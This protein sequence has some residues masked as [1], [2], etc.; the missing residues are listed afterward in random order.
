VIPDIL[1][2]IVED[3]RRRI[4][5]VGHAQGL[6]ELIDG[7]GGANSA[8]AGAGA[9]IAAGAGT[10]APAVPFPG[11][12]I[13]E[14]K[15]RSPSR[16][17]LAADADPV[18]RAGLYRAAGATSVSVLT[19]ED[20]FA[21]S[22]ADLIAVKRAYP[23]LAV[24]R[25]DFLLD[26]E[27]LRVSR[28]A[29]ADAVLL[30][31]AIL[32]RPT[33]ARLLAEAERLGLAALVEVHNEAELELVAPLRPKLLGINSRDLRTF[34]VDLLGPVA[35]SERIDW[36]CRTVFESGVFGRA[37]ARLARDAGFGSVLVG[38]AVVKD[39]RRVSVLVE[40]MN[41]NPGDARRGRGPAGPSAGS[42]WTEI[43]RRRRE[44][45]LEA[46]L[47][48]LVKVCGITNIEDARLAVDLGADLLG[49]IYATS[50]RTAPEGLAKELRAA[51]ITV[52]LVGVV[53]E[54]EMLP[55]IAGAA[56]PEAIVFLSRA[57]ADLR[58]GYLSAL[59]LHGASPPE[60]ALEF[61][62]PAY[63]AVRF[64]TP[65][66]ATTTIPRIVTPRFLVDAYDSR[67]AGG[68]GHSVSREIMDTVTTAIDE[69]PH[70]AL[71][72]AGGL[73]PD[74][75]TDA[76]RRW[77]PELID[78]SGGLEAEPGR[79]DPDRLR[80]FFAAVDAAS[81]DDSKYDPAAAYAATRNDRRERKER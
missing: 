45:R 56:V 38:E 52:P 15:R 10:H 43:A 50:P 55:G 60:N 5:A 68:T 53:V 31:A 65:G 71:W 44:R 36:E 61:A 6:E 70:G 48:P 12:V 54:P 32:D 2:R 77:H 18:E 13:C 26:E 63:T 49:L 1:A 69:G 58:A 76:I 29:G 42:F 30:I 9:G 74:T 73:N 7:G 33:M 24:L 47:R 59:Q 28:R 35:L 75:V 14:V 25:K 51:G 4:A 62:W 16:G 34:R 8:A 21:G 57:R 20:H 80:A 41:R 78:A 23:D 81:R 72:L 22:L 3:R 17:D 40:E 46:P 19:E 11:P 27:D 37:E 67:A 66:E 39:P 79:K 64:R